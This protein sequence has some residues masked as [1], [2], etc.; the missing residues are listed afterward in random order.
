MMSK[1]L[2]GHCSVIV[3]L[4]DNE[5]IALAEE[6]YPDLIL[7]DVQPGAKHQELCLA[8]KENPKTKSIPVVLISASDHE[9][10][11]RFGKEIHANGC[12]TKPLDRDR[13]IATVNQFL[14]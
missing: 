10:L 3:S 9:E 5:C 14:L 11:Q 7:L 12:L 8:L 1:N 4:H 13:L 2:Q 6:Y